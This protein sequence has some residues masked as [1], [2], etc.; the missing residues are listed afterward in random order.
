[1]TTIAD[2]MKQKGKRRR[3]DLGFS[4]YTQN[5]EAWNKTKFLKIFN[6]NRII[7]CVFSYIIAIFFMKNK[8]E[9]EEPFIKH[10][11]WEIPITPGTSGR[12]GT[13]LTG[14]QVQN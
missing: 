10:A 9:W 7:L 14:V 12:M 5:F 3:N 11:D 6:L 13:I 1:M 4:C 8:H 2:K